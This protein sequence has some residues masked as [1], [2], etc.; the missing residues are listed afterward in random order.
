MAWGFRKS[1][2][3]MPGVRLTGSKRGLSVSAGPRRMKVSGNTRGERR[4][5]ASL[6]GFFWRK[7]I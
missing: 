7:R 6:W 4:G 3:L 1:R 5:S 2:K